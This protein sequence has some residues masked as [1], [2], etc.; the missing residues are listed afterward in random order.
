MIYLDVVKWNRGGA[1][2]KIVKKKYFS[3]YILVKKL[4][5]T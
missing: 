3:K 4:F 5:K 1:G 2:D